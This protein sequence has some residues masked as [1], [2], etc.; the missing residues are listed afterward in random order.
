MSTDKKHFNMEMNAMKERFRVY[1][2]TMVQWANNVIALEKR[3]AELESKPKRKNV[4]QS[5]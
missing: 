3:V 4:K 5:A 2:E 1:E